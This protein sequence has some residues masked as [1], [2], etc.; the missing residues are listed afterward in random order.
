MWSVLV[1]L[2]EMRC[3]ESEG[4]AAQNARSLLA[5]YGA[6]ASCDIAFEHVENETPGHA[7]ADA[8]LAMNVLFAVLHTVQP[9][10]RLFDPTLAEEL[11]HYVAERDQRRAP[12]ALERLRQ[13]VELLRRLLVLEQAEEKLEPASKDFTGARREL[14]RFM[15][16]V[17]S[18]EQLFGS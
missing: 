15:L 9:E 13:Q 14:G 8:V 4:R 1:R 17:Y 11:A 16:D 10:L 5:L 2:V 6:L 3:R 12:N 18:P 7:W